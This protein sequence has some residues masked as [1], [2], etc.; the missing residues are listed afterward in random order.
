MP[1]QHFHRFDFLW[2]KLFNIFSLLREGGGCIF[3]R[4]ILSYIHYH[5]AKKIPLGLPKAQSCFNKKKERL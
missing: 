5:R 2:G 3:H 1:H 4:S